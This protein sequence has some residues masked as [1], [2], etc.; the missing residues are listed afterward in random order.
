MM[1]VVCMGTN[2][3]VEGPW[4]GPSLSDNYQVIITSITK[5]YKVLQS[6][7]KYPLPLRQLPGDHH[8]TM[9]AALCPGSSPGMCGML[10]TMMLMRTMAMA[11]LR[12]FHIGLWDISN[13][14]WPAPKFP[15]A[16]ENA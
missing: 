1:P 5:Y 9:A 8:K 6:I 10:L 3:V 16:L 4:R 15:L 2:E 13:L 7:T 11:L 12:T 14:S